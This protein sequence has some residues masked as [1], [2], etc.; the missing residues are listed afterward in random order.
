VRISFAA[1]VGQ[2]AVHFTVGLAFDEVLAAVPMG[3][4]GAQT[5]QNLKASVFE[6]ALEGN[7]GATTLF[8]DLAEKAHDFCPVKKE[9]SGAFGFKV[10]AVAMAVRGD[11]ERVEPGFAVFNFSVGMGEIASTGA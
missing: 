6:V 9:F 10:R 4:S 7:E 2:D 5:N 1:T 11:V 3:F 8:F